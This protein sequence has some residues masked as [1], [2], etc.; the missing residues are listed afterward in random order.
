M[1]GAGIQADPYICETW[2]ELISV[3]TAKTV[4]IRMEN[5]LIFDFNE[6]QPR[7]FDS[8]INLSGQIDFN[9]CILRNFYSTALKAIQI[10]G[11]SSWE[12]LTFD[13]FLQEVTSSTNSDAGFIVTDSSQTAITITRC[14]F[15]GKVNYGIRSDK[16]AIP[17]YCTSY[18]EMQFEQCG[19]NVDCTCISGNFSFFKVDCVRNSNVRMKVI[20]TTANIVQSHSASNVQY[21]FNSLIS[22]EITVSDTTTPILSGAALSGFNVYKIATNSPM[23][24]VGNGISIFNNSLSPITS[25]MNNFIGCS[26]DQMKSAEYLYSIGFPC[27]R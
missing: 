18:N 13:N 23:V 16:N 22:G 6:I 21:I 24:Y 15:Y 17:F 9:G 25:V 12:N 4:Y 26:T 7:G 27:Y 1:T 20:S 10:K 5:E 19:F 8:Q 2:A 3:S 14:N 11:G